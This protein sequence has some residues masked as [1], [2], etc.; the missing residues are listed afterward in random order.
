MATLS[1]TNTERFLINQEGQD[2]S[3]EA[4][5]FIK[6][7]ELAIKNLKKLEFPTPKMEA[8][9]YTNLREVAKQEFRPQSAINVVGAR[10]K[11]YL[12]PDLDAYLLVFVNGFF[13]PELSEVK[14]DKEGDFIVTNLNK[15]KSKFIKLVEPHLGFLTRDKDQ[16]FGNLN[17][18]FSQDG[19]FVYVKSG[20]QLDKPVHVIN[21]VDGDLVVAYP[22][23]L[24][25]A[26]KNAEQ[27]LLFL[28][29]H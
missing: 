6:I 21:L 14:E 10:L 28:M 22:R 16:F 11:S 12:I 18:A 8:W 1:L 27:M 24:I 25:V 2:F 5:T 9:K 29:K 13:V 20:K 4:K 23:N 26:E 17:A 7:R 3:H 15:A 19:A